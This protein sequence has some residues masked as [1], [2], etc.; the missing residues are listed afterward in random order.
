M[1]R[2]SAATTPAPVAA[3][4]NTKSAVEGKKLGPRGFQAAGI[5]CGIKTTAGA[6]D[7]AL[8]YSQAPARVAGLFTQNRVKA[9]PVIVTKQRLRRGIC[10]ALIVNSGNANAC[11]G[12]QGLTDAEA[13]AQLTAHALHL[14]PQRVFVASTGVIGQPLPMERLQQGIPSLV[15]KLS[16]EGFVDAAQAIMTTDTHP[17][18]ITEKVTADNE[19]TILGM[20]KGA[21]MIRPQLATMLAFLLTDARVE[22]KVL[23]NLLREGARATF[24]RITV[25]GDTST[26]DML[27]LMA[28][29]EASRAALYPGEASFPRFK[30]ALFG[31]MEQLALAIVRDGE[32]RTKVVKIVVK[33]SKGKRAAE[34]L[35]FRV[36]HSPLVKTAFFGQDPN[37]GRIMAALGV[38]GVAFDPQKVSIFF[39]DVLVVENGIAAHHVT[40]ERQRKVLRQEEFTL[41]IDLHAGS[42]QTTILTTDLSPD[43]VRINASY[44]T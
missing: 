25:D 36:A 28:N 22:T 14:L 23:T 33:G 11:T 44:H 26:N 41:T 21:G 12:E 10:Q 9:A 38:A 15:A 34:Q 16:D 4:R 8:I 40:E 24:Q 39:D 18:I 5:A 42:A 32:G 43:Y 37:W 7:L 1:V 6:K 2:R 27:L 20:A 35:A 29:G 13:M 31:V 17:K 30:E 19:I 3:V